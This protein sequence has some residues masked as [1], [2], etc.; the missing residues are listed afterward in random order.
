MI[1]K[2]EDSNIS[3]Y[4]GSLQYFYWKKATHKIIDVVRPHYNLEKI[5]QYLSNILIWDTQNFV[6]NKKMDYWFYSFRKYHLQYIIIPTE[7]SNSSVPEES[8][9]IA[10][11]KPPGFI[12]NKNKKRCYFNATIQMLYFDI[13]FRQFILNIDCDNIMNFINI[14]NEKFSYH[15]QKILIVKEL[16]IVLARCI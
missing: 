16:Q 5:R 12:N 13:L 4:R 10:D 14:N 3:I 6:R 2:T 15:Y 1:K 9:F 7:Y 11:M 8:R